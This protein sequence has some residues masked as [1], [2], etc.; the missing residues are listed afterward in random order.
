MKISIIT[1]TFNSSKTISDCISSV[2][3]QSYQLIE[4]IIIDGV[5][6]DNTLEIIKALPNR[7]VKII[8][9]PDEG[10]YDA[11]N[12]GINLA[13]GDIIGFLNSDDFYVDNDVISGIIDYFKEFRVDCVFA[14]VNY[15]SSKNPKNI[16]RKWKSGKYKKGSFQMG[17]HPAHPAFFVKKKVYEVFGAF[18]LEYKLSADFE[19]MLRFLEKEGISNYYSEKAI[20]NMRLGGATSG[21]LVNIFKQNIECYKAFKTNGISISP[22]YPLLRLIPKVIQFLK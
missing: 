15:V 9:E 21:S 18:N 16:V 14:N 20:I 1:A 22:F 2:S 17:W 10:I 7:V 11:M 19:L 6:R 3:D 4:H 8:S 13:K 5:S 12:K